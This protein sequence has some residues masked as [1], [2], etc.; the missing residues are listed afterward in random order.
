MDVESL[1]GEDEVW[2]RQGRVTGRTGHKFLSDCWIAIKSL[3]E[4]VDALFHI[5]DRESILGED[6]V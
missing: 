5:V 2:S 4:F 1:L 3:H 6:E